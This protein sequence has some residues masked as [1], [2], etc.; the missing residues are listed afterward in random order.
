[1]IGPPNIASSPT[2]PPIAIAAA[3][4]TARVSVAT[5]MITNIRKAVRTSSQ[6]NDCPCEPRWERRA[7][8]GDVAERA[9]QDRRGRKAPTSCARPVGDRARPGKVPGE[10]EGE[11]DGGVEVGAGDVADRVDHHHDHEAER[12]RDADVPELVRLGVDHDR[13]AAGEDERERADRLGEQRA[14]QVDS[15]VQL[16]GRE[17]LGRSAAGRAASISSRMTRTVSTSWPAGSSSSQ[18]S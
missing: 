18:S 10:R 12:D 14:A 3:S 2:V 11:R 5:A 1:M 4:P 8:V 7:D 6:R 13:A 17:K 15:I 16:L 9:S